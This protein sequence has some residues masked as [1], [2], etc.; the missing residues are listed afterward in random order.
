[1][2]SVRQLG[3]IGARSPCRR[4]FPWAFLLAACFACALLAPARLSAQA[5]RFDVG[6][7]ASFGV[8][9]LGV[10][11]LFRVF[12]EEF[13]ALTCRASFAIVRLGYGCTVDLYPLPDTDVY[14]SVGL[15]DGLGLVED[16]ERGG[17]GSPPTSNDD[18]FLTDLSGVEAGVGLDVARWGYRGNL[19][20]GV[21]WP[22]GVAFPWVD[23]ARM[24][25]GDEAR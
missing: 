25:D 12:P 8:P 5:R 16:P 10:G 18:F 23:V 1:M 24:L 6:V 7:A 9:R 2:R 20:A 3:G 11:I 21:S 13:V 15:V 17:D 19:A 22:G 14:L 4:R